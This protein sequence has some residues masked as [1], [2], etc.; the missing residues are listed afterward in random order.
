MLCQYIEYPMVIKLNNKKKGHNIKFAF[1]LNSSIISA[2]NFSPLFVASTNGLA[3]LN[4][5]LEIIA[6][7]TDAEYPCGNSGL[8]GRL[9]SI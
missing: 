4:H 5:W 2:V 7:I 9:S 1:L 3:I 6:N 8:S